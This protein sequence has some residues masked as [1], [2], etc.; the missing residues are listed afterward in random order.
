MSVPAHLA[1]ERAQAPR[2]EAAH[3]EACAACRELVD[4]YRE[5]AQALGDL[6]LPPAPG[7]AAGVLARIEA[8]REARVL[9][10]LGGV[11]LA[12]GL[13]GAALLLRFWAPAPVDGVA[14]LAEAAALARV[15]GSLAPALLPLQALVAL[16][17]VAIA[18]PAGVL[19]RAVWPGGG[20]TPPLKG[21]PS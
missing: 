5:L 16:G 21:S 15:A 19:A 14:L 12:A 1:D 9:L 11:L 20:E 18:V 3:L 17:C 4:G 8:R 6:Q 10:L 7:L 2:D 13:W